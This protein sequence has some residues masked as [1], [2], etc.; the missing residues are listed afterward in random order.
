MAR[1]CWSSDLSIAC[2]VAAAARFGRESE[3]GREGIIC[4][5]QTSHTPPHTLRTSLASRPI[6]R[7]VSGNQS[8]DNGM[9]ALAISPT[10]EAFIDGRLRLQLDSSLA[11]VAAD[12]ELGHMS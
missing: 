2:S 11:P 5:S 9:G 12:T 1:S 8:A 3:A 4:R 6:R 7:P 10:R